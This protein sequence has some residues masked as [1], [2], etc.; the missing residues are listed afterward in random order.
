MRKKQYE[1]QG[2]KHNQSFEAT[3]DCEGGTTCRNCDQTKVMKRPCRDDTD[4]V[5]Q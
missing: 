1:Y 5:M 2:E 4:L 3:Y